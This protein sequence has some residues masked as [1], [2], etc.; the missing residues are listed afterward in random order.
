MDH[1]L[2]QSAMSQTASLLPGQQFAIIPARHEIFLF[3]FSTMSE[4]VS[5]LV[6]RFLTYSGAHDQQLMSAI[7][8]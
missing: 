6:I 2:H 8:V 1:D 4:K 7:I 3:G 5:T